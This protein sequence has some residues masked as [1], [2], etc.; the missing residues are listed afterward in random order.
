MYVIL[1]LSRD[2]WASIDK[3]IL[4]IEVLFEVL[5][6]SLSVALV[7]AAHTV[8][9]TRGFTFQPGPDAQLYAKLNK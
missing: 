3:T 6:A 2:Y 7:V 9:Q 1:V 5:N 8:S 4:V